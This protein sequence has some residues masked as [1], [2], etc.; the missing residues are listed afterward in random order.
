MLE[1]GGDHQIREILATLLQSFDGSERNGNA[2]TRIDDPHRILK[3]IDQ[4]LDNDRITYKYP[5]GNFRFPTYL[6]LLLFFFERERGEEEKFYQ[7]IVRDRSIWRRAWSAQAWKRVRARS[8]QRSSNLTLQHLSILQKRHETRTVAR[9]TWTSNSS[10][11]SLS[12]SR[13][14]FSFLSRA[15][16]EGARIC[17]LVPAPRVSP[18]NRVRHRRDPLCFFLQNSFPPIEAATSIQVLVNRIVADDTRAIE[19]A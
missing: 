2:F 8:G 6:L 18:D 7:R 14:L 16:P 3:S 15:P 13:F 5:L 9:T 10:C 19:I 12:H 4:H 17:H 11:L 1:M